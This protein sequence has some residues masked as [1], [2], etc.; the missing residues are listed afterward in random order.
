M[1]PGPSSIGAEAARAA[2][3][4]LVATAYDVE[5]PGSRG[6]PTGREGD[7]ARRTG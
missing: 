4:P 5:V 2:A 3:L 6:G 1:R 7:A